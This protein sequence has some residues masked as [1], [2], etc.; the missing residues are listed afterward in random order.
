MRLVPMTITEAKQF[1]AVFHRHNKPP[2]GALFAVGLEHDGQ[3]VGVAITGRPI[4]R[5]LDDGYTAEVTRT[6]TRPECP[7]GG[8]S[9]LLNSCRKAAAGMGYRKCVT[10]TLQKESG[11]SLRGAGWVQA[12]LLKPHGGWDCPSRRRGPGT[13][14]NLSKIR[15]EI[16]CS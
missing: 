7:K 1:V 13:V 3:I 4:A 8:I 2:V 11:A 16:D 14:D 6:C 9:K 12:D 5:H 10:Y 15:W